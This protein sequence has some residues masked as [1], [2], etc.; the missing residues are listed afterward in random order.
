MPV[1]PDVDGEFPA[2]LETCE[3]AP[4]NAFRMLAHAPAVGAQLLRQVLALLTETDLDPELRELIILRVAQRC[5][6]EYVWEQQVAV[7]RTTVTLL[8]STFA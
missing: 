4:S 3:R 5:L 7:A 6:G 2:S 1:A 8:H